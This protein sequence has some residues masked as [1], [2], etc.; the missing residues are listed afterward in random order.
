MS[1]LNRTQA[2][3]VSKLSVVPDAAPSDQNPEPESRDAEIDREEPEAPAQKKLKTEVK[4][5][6]GRV[7]VVEKTSA[8]VK[9]DDAATSAELARLNERVSKLESDR[10]SDKAALQRISTIY[11]PNSSVSGLC[12]AFDKIFHHRNDNRKVA[13]NSLYY[14]P[15]VML[16]LHIFLQ[17]GSSSGK[18]D[19][20]TES[21]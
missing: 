7:D 21:S 10:E 19:T 14:S 11:V 6:S 13:A 9:T 18:F 15:H 5:L 17:I 12:H 4:D 16:A 1:K 20:K 2:P 3:A 8:E